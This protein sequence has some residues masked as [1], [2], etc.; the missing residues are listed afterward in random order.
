MASLFIPI[1]ASRLMDSNDFDK[2]LTNNTATNI[3]ITIRQDT[4]IG[5][6][7]AS[8][9]AVGLYQGGAGTVSFVA[10]PNVTINGTPP[11]VAQFGTLPVMRVGA[12]TWAYIQ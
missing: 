1:T 4:E 9:I 10:G 5:I 12:N 3:A 2:I 6:N 8:S 11:T 7:A